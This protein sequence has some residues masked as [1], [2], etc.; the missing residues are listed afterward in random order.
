MSIITFNSDTK[1]RKSWFTGL[2]FSHPAKM[3]LPLQL[4]IIDNYTQPGD[5][6][7]DPLA[8]SGTV[9]VGCSM[10][11]HVICVE[12][13]KKFC[14]MMQGNWAK[15][16]QRGSQLGHSMGT[17]QI[18]QGDARQLEG[19]LCDS[20][21]SSPPYGNRLSDAEV[22]DN[23][24]Q[25]MSYRQA[26][27][28][29]DKI[30]TS[31]PYAAQIQ[32]SGADAARKRI[33]EG[34]YNGLRPDVWLSKGNIAGSTYGDGYSKDPDNI[35][36][37]PYGKLDAV[38]TSP[39][40]GGNSEPY[41]SKDLLRIRTEMGRDPSKPSAQT[42]G[43]GDNPNNLGNL[44]YGSIDSIITSPPYE[45]AIGEKHHSPAH[46][47]ISKDIHW[48]TTYTERGRPDNIGNL[49][50]ASYLEA[51]LQVYQQCFAVLKPQ[52]LLILVTKNFI[53]NRQ[54]VRLDEDTIKLCET[55][56]FTFKERH[57]R[58][59]QSQSFWRTIALLKCDNRKGSKTNPKC[60]LGLKCPV[61]ID[62]AIIAMLLPMDTEERIKTIEII[63]K[64][65]PHFIN[66]MPKLDKED[67]LIFSKE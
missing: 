49:K 21:I 33:A 17:A 13:E 59:L 27:G 32:G 52:G 3:M 8:G 19:I 40:H 56:G 45:E 54:E 15:I 41:M 6:I 43:Y 9:M 4:W 2:S 55:A 20:I 53:R 66:T 35:G 51:M 7:L 16:Q 12:L 18:I 11:R 42:E 25:R 46:E 50:S 14:D 23:D 1:H 57:Y 30:I 26:L 44:S 64:L 60:K 5:V 62:K 10:G 38:I 63:E 36:C 48:D 61:K 34:K 65:C 24:P 67:I 58:K 28:K 39:P 29:V 37:L 47:R 31:P 22:D